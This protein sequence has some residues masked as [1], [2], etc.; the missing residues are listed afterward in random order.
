[1]VVP[2]S[3]FTEIYQNVKS[4]IFD[5]DS[6]SFLDSI[7]SVE[8]MLILLEGLESLVLSSFKNVPSHAGKVIY[9]LLKNKLA[10]FILMVNKFE[11][12]QYINMLSANF[13]YNTIFDQSLNDES[14]LGALYQYFLDIYGVSA[15]GIFAAFLKLPEKLTTEVIDNV[16]YR[17]QDNKSREPFKDAS[18]TYRVVCENDENA[19]V[20]VVEYYFANKKIVWS[21]AHPLSII[22]YGLGENDVPVVS[23]LFRSLPRWDKT[24]LLEVTNRQQLLLF[25]E[26]LKYPIH[27]DANIFDVCFFPAD[28][29]LAEVD[30]VRAQTSLINHVHYL[31]ENLIK[32]PNFRLGKRNDALLQSCR[33]VLTEA[34]KSNISHKILTDLGNFIGPR[35]LKIV[36]VLACFITNDNFVKFLGS[37]VFSGRID[38]SKFDFDFDAFEDH[39]DQPVNREQKNYDELRCE[40]FF[41]FFGDV[42]RKFTA[43]Q[44]KA[45]MKF[46]IKCSDASIIIRFYELMALRY[47]L[48]ARY[49]EDNLATCMQRNNWTIWKCVCHFTLKNRKK[50]FEL[51]R[52]FVSRYISELGCPEDYDFIDEGASIS[53]LHRLCPRGVVDSTTDLKISWL[54]NCPYS[55]RKIFCKLISCY[56]HLSREEHREFSL[57]FGELLKIQNASKIS[58]RG[59][60]NQILEIIERFDTKTRKYPEIFREVLAS[61]MIRYRIKN[62]KVFNTLS[63]DPVLAKIYSLFV[64][65]FPECE[66][67]IDLT[68]KLL[69]TYEYYDFD[70][71][72]ILYFYD[73][74]TEDTKRKL[75]TIADSK[76]SEGPLKFASLAV[77]VRDVKKFD[78]DIARLICSYY[79]YDELIDFVKITVHSDL[80]ETSKLQILAHWFFVD[81]FEQFSELEG[82]AFFIGVICASKMHF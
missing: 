44:R 35:Y 75:L 25:Y 23:P 58:P 36:Q 31:L 82:T 6:L 2:A 81:E 60:S 64:L 76:D 11:K 40:C 70:L 72:T 45:M 22:W 38:M 18:S 55:Y 26:I 37:N 8:E 4:E 15:V 79:F 62:E 10:L 39:S 47:P 20:R 41:G 13:K 63:P 21:F 49:M 61:L 50:F 57:L 28:F 66:G 29:V 53:A 7:E 12:L 24:R 54:E 78:K 32:S 9:Y 51:S 42:D 30:D 65:S 43:D 1:M 46:A 59:D 71:H 67:M 73:Y 5:W 80:S 3:Q 69:M 19:V 34:Q 17:P 77:R 27:E 33:N 56:R 16:L 68:D 74:Y 14:S 52:S 48:E